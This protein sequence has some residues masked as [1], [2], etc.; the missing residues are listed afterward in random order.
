MKVPIH[1]YAQMKKWKD[2]IQLAQV[3]TTRTYDLCE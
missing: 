1:I 3:T 2:V